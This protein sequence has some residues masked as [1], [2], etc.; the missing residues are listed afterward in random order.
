MKFNESGKRSLLVYSKKDFWNLP[1]ARGN[2]TATSTTEEKTV[3]GRYQK[4]GPKCSPKKPTRGRYA[5][6]NIEIFNEPSTSNI[7]STSAAPPK[8]QRIVPK[9]EDVGL[10]HPIF[11]M[12]MNFK[13]VELK[14]P[15]W[16]RFMEMDRWT[17]TARRR[18][19]TADQKLVMKESKYIFRRLNVEEVTDPVAEEEPEPW[20]HAEAE[21]EQFSHYDVDKDEL[22]SCKKRNTCSNHLTWKDFKEHRETCRLNGE[23]PEFYDVQKLISECKNRRLQRLQRDNNKE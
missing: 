19:L 20:M 18:N 13:K 8:P 11:M 10:C 14:V 3:G 15:H 6:R 17:A 2:C 12:Q 16:M 21:A 7:P 4:K 1:T 23:D 22:E 9:S 5:N